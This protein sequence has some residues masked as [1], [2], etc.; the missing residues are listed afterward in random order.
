MRLS[1]LVFLLALLT[2]FAIPAA[3]LTA[4]SEERPVTRDYS[5]VRAPA[6][7]ARQSAADVLSK[8]AGCLTCHTD[9]DAPSMH[10]SPAVQLGCVDCHG[11]NPAVRGRPELGFDHPDYV[12]ARN[13]AHVLP[14][15]PHGWNW[16]SSANPERSYT[17]LNKEAPEYIR[18]VNPGDYRVARDSCGNC[19]MPAIE[20]AERSLMATGAMLWGGAAYNNGIAPF[21]NYIFGEAYTAKGEPAKLLSPGTPPGTVTPAQEARGALAALYPLPTWNVMPPADVFRVFEQGGR[22][23]GSGFAEVGLPN[24]SGSIQRLEEPGRPDLKQSNRGPGTGLRVAIPVLNIHKTRLNDPYTWFMGT[25]DQPGDYRSSGCT[26]CHVIYANDREPRHSLIYASLGRD[27]QS[28]TRDPTI[29]ALTQRGAHGALKDGHDAESG[30]GADKR[31]RGHPLQHV[32][33]RAIPT[34]QCMNCHMH[35][36][37]IFLNSYLGYT[38]WDYE[39]DAPMM[40]PEKQKYPTAAEVRAVNDRN[41][42]GAAPRGKWGDIDF[43]RNLYDLNPELKDTQFADYHGHGWAFRAI[44]KRDRAGNLLDAGGNMATWGTDKAHIISPD[45]PEKWRR[46]GEGKFVKPGVNP[47]KAVHMMDIHAEKG[48]QCADCHFAQDAH[49]NGL[50]QGEVANAVEIGCKDCHGTADALPTLLTSGPA[51]PPK[52]TDLSLLRNADG[53][54]RFEWRTD[55]GG[56]RHLTQRSVV[57]PNLS[58]DVKLVV[59]AVDPASPEFN[60]KAARA[61]L[62]SR[63]GADDGSFRFGPGVPMAD[64][65]HKTEEMAC[66]T[67]HLSWTTSCGGCHLPVEANWKTSSHHFEGEETRNFATYNPQVARDDMFQLGKHMTTKGAE[68]APVRSTSALVLSSTNANRERI[69]I[70]QPPISA[71]GFS[72]QAFAPHFP[73]TVRLSETKTCSDCHLSEKDDNNAILA[74]TLLLG[75]NFVNF[76]GLNSWVGLEAGFEAVRVTEWDEPQAVIGSY[77]QRYAYPDYW[78]L[79]VEQNG[80]ELKNWT[81]GSTFDAKLSG[82]T[83]P[84]EQFRNVTQG[85][86]DQVGCLQLRGEYMFV[87]E[88]RGGFKVYDVASVAN[89]GVSDA[90]ISAPFSPLGQDTGVKSKNATCMAIATTQPIA[91]TRN[92]QMAATMLAD[93]KGQPLHKADGTPMSLRD[94]NQEQAFEPIYSYAVVTDSEE[95]LILVDIDTLADGEFRNNRLTRALTWNPDHVLDGARHVTLAGEVAYITAKVGLVAVDL[96]DPLHPKVTAVRPLEDARASAVQF[97]YLWVTD[98]EGLKLF[99]VTDLRNPVAVASGTVHLTDARR[100]YVAR[101]YAYVA[102]GPEGLVIVD[103]LRPP[104]PQIYRKETFG[105]QMNDVSDVVVGSTN[106]S[107]FAYVADGV[108]GLKVVQLTSPSS[109][110]NFYGFSPAPMPELIAW[111]RTPSAARALSKGLDR[112]RAV[113]E[114]GGQIAVF[115]RLGSRPFTRAEMEALFLNRRGVPFKVSDEVDMRVWVPRQ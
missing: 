95:G 112:D 21:K 88:G 81:R 105:G 103:V 38:M 28:I 18:F 104:F 29:A 63:S 91:P 87:A 68:V 26:A 35:Q 47:G 22:T 16:P 66:F 54:R 57:D 6:A 107:L 86:R 97:R 56:R 52:G 27:G 79:H 20:A 5:L 114:T 96:H 109:Q 30:Q 53:Q 102:G 65:A 7:P 10:A 101:T 115:G 73:H 36:P 19:H 37:N 11:G 17:L 83:R 24:L 2:A 80:R 45:D 4:S 41:P 58:W 111:A 42:E 82:E 85:T 44:F 31:E 106:A 59:N 55:V 78:R 110:P 67:C 61:K 72:S 9:S 15:Y 70:Q 60:A 49:G 3:R 100:L 46:A 108:N 74:Q 69:Y 62:M 113:D 51:A 12:A 77:L 94:A 93:A 43:L 32:F 39:A 14:R 25:N 75:T 64:R 84:L 34:A 98:R 23:N 48:M 92:R 50:I 99:D 76:V 33:T 90:V 40:W 8:S 13:K 1:R 71:A 89:K